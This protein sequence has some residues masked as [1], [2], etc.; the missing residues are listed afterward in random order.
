MLQWKLSGHLSFFRFP[1]AKPFLLELKQNIKH[2]YPLRP[3]LENHII[4]IE[5]KFLLILLYVFVAQWVMFFTLNYYFIGLCS[6]KK[7]KLFL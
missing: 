7:K 4:C 6:K 1:D 5:K 3:L 2:V